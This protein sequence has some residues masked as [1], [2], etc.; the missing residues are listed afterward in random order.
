MKMYTILPV[1]PDLVELVD[2][3]SDSG[4]YMV[5]LLK[6][7]ERLILDYQILKRAL[8]H[9][10]ELTHLLESLI[11]NY[12]K[13]IQRRINGFTDSSLVPVSVNENTFICL[14]YLMGDEDNPDES[15]R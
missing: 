12:N 11:K 10:E 4:Y 1:H 2:L 14:A 6:T 9:N 8:A 5:K 13:S 7:Q 3:D 15:P